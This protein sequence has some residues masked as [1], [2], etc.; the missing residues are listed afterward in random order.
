MVDI[1]DYVFFATV[2]SGFLNVI[3]SKKL[4]LLPLLLLSLTIIILATVIEVL[5][6]M[7]LPLGW[8]G[9]VYLLLSMFASLILLAGQVFMLFYR[10]TKP[11]EKR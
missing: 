6:L 1:V 5:K 11:S 2:L 4:D 3:L 10:L 8:V 9:A 7:N